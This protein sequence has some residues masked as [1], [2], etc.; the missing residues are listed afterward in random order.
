MLATSSVTAI[1]AIFGVERQEH[2]LRLARHL[3]DR[4]LLEHSASVH[5]L[6]RQLTIGRQ[7]TEC[8]VRTIALRTL[9]SF[10]N[11]CLFEEQLRYNVLYRWFVGLDDGANVEV[12]DVS[13]MTD[14]LLNWSAP[15]RVLLRQLFCC[16]QWH[17]VERHKPFTPDVS[18]RALLPPAAEQL[19]GK[20]PVE[21]QIDPRLAKACEYIITHI[22]HSRLSSN[23]LASALCISRRAF[24]HLCANFG[25]TPRGLIRNVRLEHCHSY[26]CNPT[27]V[28]KITAIAYDHGF[29]DYASFSRMFKSYF[30]ITPSALRRRNTLPASRRSRPT[31]VDYVGVSRVVEHQL[32]R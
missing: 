19:A 7:L 1:V 25:T 16:P 10:N 24:Y 8:V 9:Y 30:G 18:L 6:S 4:V 20:T 29:R 31:P 12:A 28:R 5:D 11:S 2:P 21:D 26:I 27:N 14:G 15:A 17:A 13:R 3:V 23:D 32:A 22:G